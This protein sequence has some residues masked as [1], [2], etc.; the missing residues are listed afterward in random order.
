MMKTFRVYRIVGDKEFC[1]V[2]AA[3]EAQALQ[4]AEMKDQKWEFDEV[5]S[6]YDAEEV[7]LCPGCGNLLA[8]NLAMNALSRYD[9]GYI[10]T[11]CGQKEAFEGDFIANKKC[12]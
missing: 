7:H 11:K 10:C 1:I 9:H 12:S 5:D 8:D 6:R 2:E 3:D 4:D